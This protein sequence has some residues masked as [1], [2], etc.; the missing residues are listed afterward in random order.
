MYQRPLTRPRSCKSYFP[1]QSTSDVSGVVGK[2]LQ[3]WHSQRS[4]LSEYEKQKLYFTITLDKKPMAP[5]NKNVKHIQK[6]YKNAI[7][8][9]ETYR[10]NNLSLRK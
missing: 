8:K 10:M 1:T 3:G 9:Y 6:E 5:V 4:T 2:I 7:I